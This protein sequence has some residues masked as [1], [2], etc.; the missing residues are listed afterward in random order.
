MYFR[1]LKLRAWNS[2]CCKMYRVSEIDFIGE[3]LTLVDDYDYEECWHMSYLNIMQRTGLSDL[4]NLDIYEGDVI[5]IYND[6]GTRK[7][8]RQRI[9][10]F[11]HGMF[12]VDDNNPDGYIPLA[13]LTES[14][15]KRV[16]I[17]GNIYED[18][19]LEECNGEDECEY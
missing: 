18:A 6:F 19:E 2:E 5:R 7:K 9:V 16:E 10:K 14:I 12:M 13:D 1:Q 11:G 8:W 17:V 4:Y 15:F 3:E